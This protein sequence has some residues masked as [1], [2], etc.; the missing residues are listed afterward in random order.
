MLAF[1]G[2]FIV[3]TLILFYFILFSLN[4]SNYCVLC[5]CVFNLMC[6]TV[7]CILNLFVFTFCFLNYRMD[8]HDWQRGK[9]RGHKHYN[10]DDGEKNKNSSK[11][12]VCYER[13]M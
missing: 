7:M 4:C 13:E 10:D 12:K 3:L 9:G 2:F 6:F 11:K 1:I 5:V 8:H